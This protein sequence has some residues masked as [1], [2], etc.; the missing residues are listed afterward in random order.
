MARTS[1]SRGVAPFTMK[2]GN[3]PSH[4][5]VSGA[6][7]MP[8][9]KGLRN[10]AQKAVGLTP[11]G[12]LGNLIKKKQNQGMGDATASAEGT[13]VGADA[14]QSTEDPTVATEKLQT[15]KALLDDDT[16]GQGL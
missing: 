16:L 10:I 8:F 12:M 4:N 5:E 2:S 13:I 14:T 1:K 11:V 9:L 6:S 15:I 3:T 7:P